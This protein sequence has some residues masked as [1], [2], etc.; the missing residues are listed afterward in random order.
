MKRKIAYILSLALL[1]STM[2]FAPRTAVAYTGTQLSE[3]NALKYLGLFLGYKNGAFGLDNT[4]TRNQGVILLV[5]MLGKETE[6]KSRTFANSFQDLT[7]DTRAY[8]G[9]AYANG[10]TNGYSATRF[11][12]TSALSDKQFCA[13]VLRALGYSDTSAKPDFAYEDSRTMAKNLG[14]TDSA[15]LTGRLTRGEVVDIFWRAL[16]T[17]M[18][19]H[20][21]MLYEYLMRCGVFT[22]AAW[23][24]AVEISNI[25]QEGGTDDG[26]MGAGSGNS[27]GGG[28]STTCTHPEATSSVTKAATCTQSGTRSYTC[29]TCG[30]TWTETIPASH[31]EAKLPARAPTCTESGLSEGTYCS[32]CG[33]ILKKQITIRATGHHFDEKGICRVCGASKHEIGD[34]IDIVIG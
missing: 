27:F 12:G 5:R 21:E 33:V 14:L 31:A 4:L 34:P 26:T 28:G 11:G 16:Y 13:F 25:P 19:G 32:I 7:D 17:K 2:A 10:L 22:E 18:N 6:A 23:K 9:Y 8:V 30:K 1:L 20:T 3:A 15:Q 29:P 24:K